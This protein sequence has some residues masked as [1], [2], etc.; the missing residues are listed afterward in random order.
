MSPA[1]PRAFSRADAARAFTVA[2]RALH[3]PVKQR[4]ASLQPHDG[5]VLPCTFNGTNSGLVSGVTPGSSITVDC[6]GFTADEQVSIAEASPLF[7]GVDPGQAANEIDVNDTQSFTTDGSGD[8]AA[9]FMLPD[10]FSAG[11]PAATC[12]PAQDQV[13]SGLEDCLIVAIDGA[14]NGSASL[15][16][17]VG[18]PTPQLPGYWEVA[19]DGGLFAFNASFQG[20]MGGRPL[21]K[22]IV[23]MAY[24]PDTGGYWEVASDGGLFAF[25]GAPYFGSMGGQPLSKPIVGMAFDPDTGGYWEV[26]SDGGLFA[27]NAPFE[28]SMGG[29]ALAKP[30]VAMAFDPLTGGYWEVASDGGVFAF[31]GAPFQGSMGGQSLNRPIVGMAFDP[32]SGGYWEVASDGGL[33]AFGGAGYYGSMGGQPLSKPIVGMV[34]DAYTGGYWE[35]ASDGGLFAFNVPFEGSMGGKPLNKPIVGMATNLVD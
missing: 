6:T 24:D 28:G 1:T 23:G 22:P 20:S 14:G 2:S 31:G 7:L 27:F 13:S 11:D 30:I 35:V 32:V 34:G 21:S 12:P 26:A 18:Q 25:G 8:L 33:F 4:R 9:S 15:V 19:S 29:Q 10:P 17:Y 5:T 16:S 3:T